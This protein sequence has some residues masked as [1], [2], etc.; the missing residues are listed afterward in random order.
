MN[1]FRQTP[2]KDF[3]RVPVRERFSRGDRWSGVTAERKSRWPV[4]ATWVALTAG[5]GAIAL[6][7]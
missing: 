5:L 1:D 3:V 7:D 6:V 4:F 2:H